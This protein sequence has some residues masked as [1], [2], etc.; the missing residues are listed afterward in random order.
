[1]FD[2]VLVANR[3]EIA[4][5]IFATLR[6][7]GVGSVAVYTDADAGSAHVRAADHAVRI[8]EGPVIS[9]YLDVTRILDATAALSVDAIHPGYGFLS[10]NAAFADAC[11]EA[12]VVWIGPSPEHLRRFGDKAEARAFAAA[13]GVPLLAGSGLLSGIDDAERE[14]GRIG[15]PVM[16]K[17]TAGGGGIGIRRCADA[18]GLAEAYPVIAGLAER[19]FGA[20]GVLVER[21]VPRARHIEVQIFGAAG[22][23]VDLG[24]RDC[25]AQRRNQKVIE[26]TPP[27]HLGE[28]VTE[29]MR[30]AALRLGRAVGYR[31]AGTVEFVV[32]ADRDQ[33]AF[34]EVNTRL[35]VEHGVTEAVTGVDLVEWMVLEAAGELRD[36]GARHARARPA[37]AAIEARLY[38]EDPAHEDR[39]SWGTIVEVR[40]PEEAR[41]DTWIERGT[42]V[43]PFYDPLLAKLIVTGTT[44]ADAVQAL[45]KALD[46]TVL[47]GIATNL[48]HLRAAVAAA[49]FEAGGY[50]TT[51]LSRVAATTAVTVGVVDGGMQTTVQDFPG[52]LGHWAVGVPPSG[53]MDDLAFR[54]ANR[55]VGNEESAAALE[56]TLAG[57][58]LTF[59]AGAVFALT[60][61]PMT[62]ELDG[63]EVAW[64]TVTR[65]PAGSTLRIGSPIGGGSRAYLAVGGGID[66][67]A[68]LGSR[69]TFLL[70]GFGGLAG[71]ALEAGDVITVGPAGPVADGSAL[72]AE[73][74]PGYGR[75][76]ELA[77]TD[78]PHGAPDFFTPGGID[79][80]FAAAWEVHHHSDRTGV[81]LVGPSP[82]WARSDGGEAGLHPSNIH[83]N[84]YAIG[85]VD[86]TGDMPVIL[87]P[88]GPS[89]G[90]F[91]CP[92]TVIA[93]ERWKLGQLTPGDR[94]RFRRLSHDDA[95]ALDKRQSEEIRTLTPAPAGAGGP[96]ASGGS[97]AA[98]EP[99]QVKAGPPTGGAVLRRPPFASQPGSDRPEVTLRRAGDR[100]VLVEYGPNVL[101]LELRLRVHALMEALERAAIGGVEELAP[102]IRSLQV[103]YDPHRVALDDLLDHIERLDAGLPGLDEL[104]VPSR[105]VHLPLSWDDPS[106]R[107][108]IERYMRVVRDDAPWCPWNIEFIRRING[109]DTVDDVRRIVFEASYVVLGLGDVYLGAPVATPLDPRHRLVTTKYNPARTWTP[110]NAVGIGGAY[111]CVYGMEG[112]G[113][114]QF[115]G[116]TLQVWNRHRDTR[117]FR[118]DRRWL[119]RFFD[120]IRFYP[121]SA[122]ELVD[123]R[124]DFALGRHGLDI[125]DS[126]ISVAEY[127]RFLV[128]NGESIATAKTRQQTA[129]E[130]ERARW[131]ESGELSRP[132]APPAVAVVH[133]A[134]RPVP[135]GAHEIRSPVHGVVASVPAEGAVVGAG[136]RLLTVEAMKT[137]TSVPAPVAGVV[138]EVRC[139]AGDVVAPGTTLVVVSPA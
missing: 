65:A 39:P 129:F 91:V 58:S 134:G 5:R 126:E 136:D 47:G 54:L 82:E 50:P 119:L 29:V 106:T 45:A 53:P 107:T 128:A 49:E 125:A 85:T 132:S 133:H 113:G 70:G 115:V 15:Y 30:E 88:D 93:A 72:P 40:L 9:S 77:V 60:G 97:G 114:Y 123:L 138:S 101:D 1:M 63:A 96:P 89:L 81:R 46:A 78:G 131:A 57:P 62:A 11:G 8:G 2:R 87:G 122:E 94:V 41:V 12:G 3:G 19:H 36:L 67:P 52:R 120:Q 48:G 124:R 35:Q 55:L 20:G 66:V 108:A 69:S 7:M 28:A 73:I 23:V 42:E 56:I 33:A 25:S 17:A 44:R 26:E 137:E 121:V 6:R 61:A 4:C 109:L 38:A 116:R 110:E 117:D 43:T 59:D 118:G 68:Y 18:A 102:G 83:D 130:A 100:Y 13:N 75:E 127:R 80:F 31:S 71:R 92:V 34:L 139:V 64:A 10:E 112:P 21:F 74:T 14:A 98:S 104:V 22:E 24:L 135:A 27:A 99:G 37:G 76:W 84:S 86:F 95:L 111:L 105:V 103:R 51:L 16:L 32:D 90:G 79:A